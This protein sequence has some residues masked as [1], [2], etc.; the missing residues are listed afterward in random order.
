MGASLRFEI[1]LPIAYCLLHSAFCDLYLSVIL[2]HPSSFSLSPAPLS[3]EPSEQLV[4][5]G[6]PSYY[7]V[8]VRFRRSLSK[9]NIP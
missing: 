2:V 4:N 9:E 7:L 3:G 6:M 5:F 8:N 1:R